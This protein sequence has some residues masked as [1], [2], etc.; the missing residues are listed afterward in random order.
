MPGPKGARGPPGVYDAI[1]L[2]KECE[3]IAGKMFRGV[4]LKGTS[5][6]GNFDNVPFGCNPYV[7]AML[8]GEEEYK[9]IFKLLGNRVGRCCSGSFPAAALFRVEL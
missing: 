3:Q 2:T 4:C 5:L 7:P 8:W 9:E 1:D 6:D